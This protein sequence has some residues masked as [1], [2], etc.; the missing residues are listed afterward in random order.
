[1]FRRVVEEGVASGEFV[2]TDVDVVLQCM[3]AAMSQA[4]LWCGRLSGPRLEE[5][6]DVLVDTLMVLVGERPG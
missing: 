5:A 1:V 3:H 6:L 2:V 4:P